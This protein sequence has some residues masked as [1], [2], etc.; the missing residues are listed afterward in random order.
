MDKIRGSKVLV[1][2]ALRRQTHI[3]H[4]TLEEALIVIDELKP[5]KAYLTHISHQMGN[6]KDVSAELPENVFIAYDQLSIEV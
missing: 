5:E 3:S 4:Y 2:N 1:L 6:H